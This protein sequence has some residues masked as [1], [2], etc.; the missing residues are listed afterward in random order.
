MDLTSLNNVDL[1]GLIAAA[2]AYDALHKAF[3]QHV[4]D[5]K[6]GTADRVHASGWEGSAALAAIPVIDATTMKLHGADLEMAA[7][8]TSLRDY[9]DLFALAQSRLRKALGDATEKGFDVG[10]SGRVSWPPSANPYSAPGRE[11]KQRAAAEDISKRIAAALTEATE[12]DRKLAEL[13]NTYTKHAEAKSGLGLTAEMDLAS[14]N[15]A[16]GEPWKRDMPGDKASPTE[17]NSWWKSLDPQGQKWFSGQHP[18]AIRNLDG[19]PAEVRDQLN[20]MYL[21][22]RIKQLHDDGMTD[23]EEYKKLLPIQSRL[24]DN[25]DNLATQP[26]AY[27]LGVSTGGNGRAIISF[28]NPDTATDI[29]SYVPGITSTP[30]SLAR[31]PEPYKPGTNEAENTLNLWREADKRKKPGSSV[32]SV[33]WLGYDA[34]DADPTAASPEA[35]KNGA[36]D[37]AK[38]LT[39]LRAGHEGNAPAHITSIGHSYGSLVAGLATR[40]AADPP[41]ARPD[42]VVFVGSPGVGAEKASDLKMPGHVWVGAAA[43]DPVTHLPTYDDVSNTESHGFIVATVEHLIFDPGGTWYGKDPAGKTFGADRFSVDDRSAANDPFYGAHTK[44]LTPENGGP[45]LGNIAT[46]VTGNGDVQRVDGR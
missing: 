32:A 39:G 46:I 24:K 29:S 3:K 31:K 30:D 23:T 25:E 26:L 8:G 43:D 42:D 27:L 5:W 4:D 37:Y 1:S 13:L 19:I 34:P 36:P 15:S 45:S 20:R 41:Y 2:D 16:G 10:D 6:K 14:A 21:N 40:L 12:A 11:D 7:I 33:V 18:D 38:F 28:G 22:A 35:A 17:V 9:A 44:Y